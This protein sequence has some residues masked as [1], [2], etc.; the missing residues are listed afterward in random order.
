M[1]TIGPEVP[2]YLPAY[3]S[4]TSM[5]ILLEIETTASR[6]VFDLRLQ[7]SGLNPTD[8]CLISETGASRRG[9]L[10]EIGRFIK[11][12]L[13]ECTTSLIEHGRCASTLCYHINV[14]CARDQTGT[15]RPLSL[16][17]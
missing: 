8:L 14:P 4:W 7:C 2:P 3:I 9:A 15:L 6:A 13:L 10:F 5:Q 11:A 17:I 16:A 1:F 12:S